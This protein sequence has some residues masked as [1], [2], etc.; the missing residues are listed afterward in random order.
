MGTSPDRLLR[1]VITDRLREQIVTGALPA[2]TRILEERL[3]EEQGVSRVP[4]REALQRLERE[5]YLVLQPRRGATVASPSPSRALELMVVRRQL[6]ALA[7][8]LAANRR[9][10]DL[11]GE[12]QRLVD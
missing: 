1:D 11:A 2:G 8:R 6:E 9:G 7:A 10:G 3:A 12:L 5:G 4:V